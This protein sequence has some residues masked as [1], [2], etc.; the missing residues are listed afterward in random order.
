MASTQTE[1]LV[2]KLDA[3]IKGFNTKINSAKG[4]VSELGAASNKV[5]SNIS[6]VGRSAGM[7]GIQVQQF[8]GQIQG[9]QSAMLALSQQSA[10][11]GFVLG[12]PL[13]GAVVGITATMIGMAA[14]FGETADELEDL[15]S[16]VDGVIKDFDKLDSAA[17]AVAISVLSAEIKLQEKNLILTKKAMS[18]Y[19][20]ELKLFTSTDESSAKLAQFEA[21]ILK[22][23]LALKKLNATMVELSPQGIGA[24]INKTIEERS[25]LLAE[26]TI[27]IG[28]IIS[29][30]VTLAETY[31]MSGREIA[32][33]KAELLNATD[34]QKEAIN[35]SFDLI[36]AKKA[37]VA[38]NRE[39]AKLAEGQTLA[40][41]EL[42]NESLLNEQRLRDE[43]VFQ[44]MIKE[45]RFTGLESSAE[46]YFKE[47]E[48]H[49]AM[50]D[51]KLINEEEFAKAQEKL[52]QQ[53]AKRL[54]GEEKDFK[55]TESQKLN[56]QQSAIRAGMA[57]NTALFNDNKAIAAGLI[58][59]DTATA[60][61]RSL[62][63]NPYDYINVGII[64]ATGAANLA[65]ALSSSKGGGTISS[66]SSSSGSSSGAATT[67]T[68]ADTSTLEVSEQTET[69]VTEVRLVITDESG[70]EFLDGIASGLEERTRQGR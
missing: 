36:E 68:E 46:L 18:E 12:A 33:Y 24:E 30:N 52:S 14:A 26:Q 10:D 50:L 5:Q 53:Y 61:T 15:S 17:Q 16:V 39:L 41:P 70:N 43:E 45:V 9:G 32:I 54:G 48:I 4:E 20:S 64:A 11:L 7:A 6:G 37:E 38:S 21:N 13:V 22:Q 56:T 27:K 62:A 51:S 65:N 34:A 19:A 42:A 3:D 67:A 57:L 2:V 66:S 8:V 28:D 55:K 44:E 31:G 63:I 29:K 25:Q 40:D 35:T 58:V 23:E 49:Q 60:I 47:L 1:S 69:G 59:A